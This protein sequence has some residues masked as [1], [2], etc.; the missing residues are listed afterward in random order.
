GGNPARWTVATICI[1]FLPAAGQFVIS[2]GRA[3]W[4]R[5]VVAVREA[6][7]TF[8]AANLNLFFTL[9]FLAHQT[10]LALDAVTRA[11]VRR[12]VTHRRLLEWETAAEAE[13]GRRGR[14][15][16]DQYLDWMPFLA[17]G[18]GMLVWFVRPHALAAALPVLLLWGSSKLV[19]V[20][21]NQ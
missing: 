14:A 2:L 5:S 4:G 17:L 12:L 10:L 19:S 21:L 15:P 13:L 16:V 11:L 18:L 8:L 3:M 1:L 6:F 20:W 9:T 7:V